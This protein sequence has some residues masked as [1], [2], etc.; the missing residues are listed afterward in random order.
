MVAAS[1]MK[2]EPVWFE[3]MERT[4]AGQGEPPPRLAEGIAALKARMEARRLEGMRLWL[5]Y[6]KKRRPPPQVE[7]EPAPDPLKA[8]QQSLR[9]AVRRGMGI[10]GPG[11]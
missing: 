4:M 6:L 2:D 7:A 11:G 3:S 1:G 10:T 9:E 8:F 5:E